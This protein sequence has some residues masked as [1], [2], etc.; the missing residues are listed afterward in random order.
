MCHAFERHSDFPGR[1]RGPAGGSTLL[2]PVSH[3]LLSALGRCRIP[4]ISVSRE[5]YSHAAFAAIWSILQRPA[6]EIREGSG[7]NIGGD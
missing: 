6:G 7:V 2:V 4:T 5:H 3:F 1:R